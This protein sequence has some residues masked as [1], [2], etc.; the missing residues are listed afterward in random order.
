MTLRR[1]NLAKAI[2][3]RACCHPSSE[4]LPLPMTDS[5]SSKENLIYAMFCL[6]SLYARTCLDLQ[7]KENR[8][9]RCFVN[10][11]LANSMAV[12]G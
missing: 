11:E 10:T 6:E 2:P 3:T 7:E 5:V 12:C 8:T 4:V 1:L 9:Q